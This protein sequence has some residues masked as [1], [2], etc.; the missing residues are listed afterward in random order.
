MRRIGIVIATISV[1]ALLA[2]CGL[3]TFEVRI[4]GNGRIEPLR[5]TVDD[6]T[7]LVTGA[8]TLGGDAGGW[9]DSVTNPFGRP[10]QLIVNWTGGSCDHHA[11]LVFEPSG[12]EFVVRVATERADAC[13]L[14]GIV[15]SVRIG[16][17][18]P[19][20]ADLVHLKSDD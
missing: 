4:D 15:R 8:A 11:T 19:V 5:V 2:G 20:S 17:S 13:R 14:D 18:Q 12:D 9:E 16:L 7:G 3:R 1:A 6:R 10:D